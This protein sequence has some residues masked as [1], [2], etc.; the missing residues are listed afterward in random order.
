ME[1]E[2]CMYDW[3]GYR[4]I[5]KKDGT[6]KSEGNFFHMLGATQSFLN[7]D[8]FDTW[9]TS[10]KTW[11]T[12]H[13]HPTPAVPIPFSL[14]RSPLTRVKSAVKLSSNLTLISVAIY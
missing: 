6:I 2:V 5:I 3:Q 12:T 8:I 4:V 10:L 11:L 9:L 13:I 14:S 7:G 1:G